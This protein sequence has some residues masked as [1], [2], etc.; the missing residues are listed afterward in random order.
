MSEHNQEHSGRQS[1][2]DREA[3]EAAA[4]LAAENANGEAAAPQTVTIAIAGLQVTLPVKFLPG[5]V[6]S[7]NQAKVLDSAYQRQFTNNQNANA[8]SKTDAL[9]ALGDKATDADRAKYA[10]L[11]AA[12]IAAL[13]PDYEPSVGGGPRLGS[14]EKMRHDA[15]WRMWVALATEHN[16]A[17]ATGGDPVIVKAGK[18]AVKIGFVV[19]SAK[20]K[21]ETDEAFAVRKEA[22]QANRTAWIE[23]LLSLPAY[24]E[25][26]QVQLDSILAERGKGKDK[27]EAGAPVV[28]AG[29]SLLD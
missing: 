13:Y 12:E 19:P 20:T 27:A 3:A 4:K 21:E 9:A 29:D 22:A 6:L 18:A 1:R 5:H 17:V 10:T 7:D 11:T 8:K 25:R 2:K 14:M 26:I 23:K 28:E 15:T 24:A 16:N